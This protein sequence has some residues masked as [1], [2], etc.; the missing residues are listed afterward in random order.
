MEKENIDKWYSNSTIVDVLLFIL[1]LVGV[2]GLYK[3]E[4]LKPN[5]NKVLHGFLGF[6]SLLLTIIY[7]T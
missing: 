5:M 4:S 6:I 2:Y 7:L 3:T 1:P